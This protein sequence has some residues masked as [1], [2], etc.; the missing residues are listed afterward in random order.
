MKYLYCIRPVNLVIVACT[1]ILMYHLFFEGVDYK[2]NNSWVL[3]SP[4]IYLFTLVTLLITASGY[5]INDFIDFESDVVNQKSRR[6]KKRYTY[7]RYY[8][9]LVFVGFLIS[10]WFALDIGKPFLVGI[11]LLAIFMLFL[12]STIFKKKILIGN[13]IVALFSTFVLLILLYA[14][15]DG[16]LALAPL[17]RQHIYFQT[18]M[19]SIF[20][21]LISMVR[22]IVKD[23]QDIDGDKESGD[24]TLPVR[25]GVK[26]SSLVAGIFGLILIITFLLWIVKFIA[27]A[28]N[29]VIGFGL[30]FLLMPAVYITYKLFRG[31]TVS[32]S[33]FISKA[34]KFVMI[35]GLVFMFL[36]QIDL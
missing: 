8:S 13:V 19:F 5:L 27:L 36:T 10:L 26:K 12:Y 1:Q 6:L 25:F 28:E 4:K 24:V 14:E 17:V 21:F 31:I 3:S 18:I 34:C 23:I 22:E 32:D 2:L 11:Y 33:A 7:L 30:V 15:K 29:Y 20:V 16:I 35:A 9:I